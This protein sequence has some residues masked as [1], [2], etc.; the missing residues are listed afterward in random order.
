MFYKKKNTYY[1]K[2][3]PIGIIIGI[4]KLYNIYVIHICFGNITPLLVSKNKNTTV[5]SLTE[6]TLSD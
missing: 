2:K 4:F 6:V 3:Y 1:N 5:F